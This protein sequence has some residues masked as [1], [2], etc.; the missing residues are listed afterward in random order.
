MTPKQTFSVTVWD[1]TWFATTIRARSPQEALDKAQHRYGAASPP[2]C[3]GFELL[4]NHGDDWD[5]RP[6]SPKNHRKGSGG[7]R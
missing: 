4:D 3:D 7:A 5:V 2:E 1:H 6:I